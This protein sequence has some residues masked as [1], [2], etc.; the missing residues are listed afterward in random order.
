VAGIYLGTSSWDFAGWRGVFYPEGVARG[1]Y[2]AHYARSFCT[3]EVNTSFYALPEPGVLLKWI[4]SVPA[5][6]TFALKFPRLISHERRLIG[7]EREATAFLDVLRT[8]G[9]AAGP[10]LLQLPPQLTRQRYGRTLAD[11]M[12]WLAT[13]R[14]GLRIG[15]EV[16]A[17]DLMTPSFAAYLVERGLTP[18][19]ADRTGAPDL[20]E[21]WGDVAG[22]AGYVFVRWIGDSRNGPQ[23]DR[24]VVA[25]R[26]GDL[27]TWAERLAGY[28]AAGVDVFGY[29]H[30]PYEGHSPA[31][32]RRL[33][34]LLEGQATLPEW[35][36]G[37]A[38]ENGRQLALL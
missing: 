21:V 3:V 17:A 25:P 1:D 29:V 38:S 35:P 22:S 10:A 5:G 34:Q 11:F 28:Q 23:G 31:T 18:V 36:P 14:D 7:C 27:E 16:R 4:E 37:G 32:V 24:E 30:N 26:E 19:M 20:Y 9:E 33:L 15:V 2:L 8:L 6:F 12:E 13:A